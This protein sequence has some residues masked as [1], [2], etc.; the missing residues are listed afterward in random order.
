MD[1]R[2]LSE[3]DIANKLVC[4]EADK[5]IIFHNVKNGVMT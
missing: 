4:F 2:G 3:I 1:Y 5:V